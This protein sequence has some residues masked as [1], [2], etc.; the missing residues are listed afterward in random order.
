MKSYRQLILHSRRMNNYIYLNNQIADYFMN[1]T[2]YSQWKTS[3][4]ILKNTRQEHRFRKLNTLTVNETQLKMKQFLFN[5][6]HLV[7]LIHSTFR[8]LQRQKLH[9]LTVKRSSSSYKQKSLQFFQGKRPFISPIFI[10]F[11]LH[12]PS[13]GI[14]QRVTFQSL[15]TFQLPLLAV[16]SSQLS[17]VSVHLPIS[18][19]QVFLVCTSVVFLFCLFLR[20]VFLVTLP[21]SI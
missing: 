4:K 20:F 8:S 2:Y 14:P 10:V 3:Q 18:N 1:N 12:P 11:K 21:V 5:I 7:A 9:F 17:F 16:L 13:L 6:I 15:Q 19:R